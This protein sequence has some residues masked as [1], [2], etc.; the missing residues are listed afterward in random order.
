VG[1]L[2]A[3]GRADL[4]AMDGFMTTGGPTGA[5][6]EEHVMGDAADLDV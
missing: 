5:P 2:K 1:G 4:G 6:L 3:Q